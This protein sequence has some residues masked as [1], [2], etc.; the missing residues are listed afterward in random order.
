MHCVI[1][2]LWWNDYVKKILISEKGLGDINFERLR[3]A[4]I[5]VKNNLIDFDSGNNMYLTVDSLIV[6]NN[7]IT[8]SSNNTP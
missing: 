3:K 7:I 2:K 4:L 6:K 1:N 5:Y 8:S